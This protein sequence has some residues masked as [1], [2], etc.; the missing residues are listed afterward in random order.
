MFI[1]IVVTVFA[2][3]RLVL[4][5]LFFFTLPIFS[6]SQKK[7]HSDKFKEDILFTHNQ[8]LKYYPGLFH[9]ETED[10]FAERLVKALETTHDSIS[11]LEAYKKVAYLIEGIKD[12][13]LA[14]Y[15][16]KNYFPKTVKILPLLMKRFDEDFYLVY[17]QSR[18]TTLVRGTKILEI[19]GVKP[20]EDFYRFQKLMPA[21]NGNPSAKNYVS[22]SAFRALYNRWYGPLD[23]VNIQYVL[24]DSDIKKDTVLH[25]LP[26]DSAGKILASRYKANIRKN[27]GYTQVD[28]LSHTAVLD[29]TSFKGPKSFLRFTEKKFKKGL[30]KAFA[31]IEQDSIQN[32]ILD[33]RGNG[34]GA[35]VNVQTLVSYLSQEPFK[36][37]DSVY[38]K[39]A[40]FNTIF[41]SYLLLPRLAGKLIYNKKN[42]TGYYR[43]YTQATIKPQ[44]KHNYHN[45]LFVLMDGGTYS[46]STFTISLLKNMDRAIFVGTPP[47]GAN[48]GSFAGF[49]KNSKLPNS[50]LQLRIPLMQLVHDSTNLNHT[51]FVVQPDY[52]VQ[53]SFE[54]MIKNIDTQIEFIKNMVK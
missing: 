35:I 1:V 52:N 10:E 9:Y 44:K 3:Y 18:D 50:K 40:A 39:K 31:Q 2:Q 49:N 37:Y 27:L 45:R 48:W 33:L 5:L 6:F 53:R 38:L 15:L 51:N 20:I 41:K 11:I 19:N 47:G 26:A 16:P 13:H 29:I 7:I 17:N 4:A 36:L 32:L 21:D 23:S 14:V 30:E 25:F 28:S 8:L 42:E 34:G 54:D 43:Y 46:A 24:P 22:E 12:Q